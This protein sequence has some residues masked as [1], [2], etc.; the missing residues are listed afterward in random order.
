MRYVRQAA[1]ANPFAAQGL[2]PTDR[3]RVVQRAPGPE[4]PDSRDK[5]GAQIGMLIL[6]AGGV[7][8]WTGVAMAAIYFLH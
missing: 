3:L 8:F 2:S 5:G 6:L 7:A 1:P 4:A